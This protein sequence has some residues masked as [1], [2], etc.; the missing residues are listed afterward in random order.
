MISPRW[1]KRASWRPISTAERTDL[2]SEQQR[3]YH[4]H[5]AEFASPR[6]LI[7]SAKQFSFTDFRDDL[8]KFNVPTLV[9]H[10]A[11]DMIVPFEVSARRTH[12]AIPASDLVVIDGAPHGMNATHPREFNAA[13]LGFMRG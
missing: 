13:L 2:I 11:G 8:T 6:A 4:L 12:A 9:L 3:Q 10:G 5:I 7:E 1:S